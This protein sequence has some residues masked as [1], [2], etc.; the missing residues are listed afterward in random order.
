LWGDAALYGNLVKNHRSMA[1]YLA[2]FR[3]YA[4]YHIQAWK[5]YLHS[6]VLRRINI[7]LKDL[8][9]AKIEPFATK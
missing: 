4:Y 6:R 3:N 1:T 5:V 2:S 7:I 9:L 8:G